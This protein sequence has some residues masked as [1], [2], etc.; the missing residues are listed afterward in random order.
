M[1]KYFLPPLPGGVA[2]T[3]GPRGKEQARGRSTY[4]R[5]AGCRRTLLSPHRAQTGPAQGQDSA[6]TGQLGR[7]RPAGKASKQTLGARCTGE[8][9]ITPQP[10]RERRKERT[11]RSR[12]DP[13]FPT[14][15]RCAPAGL[16]LTQS[17]RGAPS[18]DKP[19]AWMQNH[20]QLSRQGRSY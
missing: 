11:P 7:K 5:A 12:K 3:K 16:F 14:Q 10:P 20:G 18:A 4:R 6:D 1:S 8:P 2:N 9:T 17:P 19:R 13:S 15:G